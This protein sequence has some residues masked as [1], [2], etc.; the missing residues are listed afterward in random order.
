MAKNKEKEFKDFLISSRKKIQA[1]ITSA[2]VWVMQKA[3]KRIW[4]RRQKRHW[5]EVDL[6][7]LYRKKSL[8]QK[9]RREEKIKR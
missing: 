5:K 6:G 7:K 4:N 1:G 8:E 3:G 9:K 2:P